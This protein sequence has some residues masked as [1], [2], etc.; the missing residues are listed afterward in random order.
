MLPYRFNSIPM[1]LLQR[2]TYWRTYVNIE[3]EETLCQFEQAIVVEDIEAQ[4]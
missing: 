1:E 4:L 3:P 2:D